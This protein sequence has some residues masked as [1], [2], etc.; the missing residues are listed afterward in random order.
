MPRSPRPVPMLALLAAIAV[1][2][3]AP[4]AEAA[5]WPCLV[6]APAEPATWTEPADLA[7]VVTRLAAARERL[8]RTGRVTM[9]YPE[10]E[11]RA[12]T[13]A[14]TVPHA[15]FVAR[16]VPDAPREDQPLGRPRPGMATPLWMT[17]F[18][19][20]EAADTDPEVIAAMLGLPYDPAARYH[21]IV[22]KDLGA[23]PAQRPALVPATR[24]A[25]GE[26]ACRHLATP[27]FPAAILTDSMA[28]AYQPTY[29]AL[30]EKLHAGG[31]KEWLSDDL[32]AFVAKEPSLAE[33]AAQRR[34]RARLRVHLQ[35]GASEL[36]RGDGMTELVGGDTRQVGVQEVFVLD[37]AP[38]PIGEYARSNR[39]VAVPCRPLDRPGLRFVEPAAR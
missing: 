23:D 2:A 22:V 20:L 13:A 39:L 31:Y 25:L 1:V 6:A 34:F 38:K 27:A 18:E 3:P 26:L 21:L 19:Q 7:E 30:L 24:E 28:P 10:A 36:F 37:P 16:F 9:R 5:W 32:E 17:T 29:R 12:L 14:G 8:A 15:R 4:P 35:F 33:P 11:L